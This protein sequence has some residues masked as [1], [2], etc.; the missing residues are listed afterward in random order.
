MVNGALNTISIR[1]EKPAGSRVLI[2]KRLIL[3][4]LSLVFI[5]PH[6]KNRPGRD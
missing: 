1:T 4:D 3:E 2:G 6:V 5:N